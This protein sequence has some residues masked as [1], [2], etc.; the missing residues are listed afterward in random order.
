L[1]LSF[2]EATFIIGGMQGNAFMSRRTATCFFVAAASIGMGAIACHP[3]DE[4]AKIRAPT[5]QSHPSDGNMIIESTKS[6]RW[7]SKIDLATRRAL[8]SGHRRLG[9]NVIAYDPPT[10]GA[11]ILVVYLLNSNN[12]VRQEIDRFG[13]HPNASFRASNR[14]EPKR[15]MISL[16]DH[17][18]FLEESS[19][20][21]E[22]GFDPNQGQLKGGMAEVS[23]G[24]VDI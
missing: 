12:T 15:F 6:V 22:I 7:S 8:Q 18:K 10:S 20:H 3:N 14:V 1:K 19:I 5:A 17:P 24:F 23:I 9:I 21:I 2:F 4:N 13:V 16:A 11:A